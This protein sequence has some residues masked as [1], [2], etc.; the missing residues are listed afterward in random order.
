MLE[1]LIVQF[2]AFLRKGSFSKKELSFDLDL[3]KDQNVLKD[4]AIVVSQNGN[5]L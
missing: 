3:S 4:I 2:L 5:I 1:T